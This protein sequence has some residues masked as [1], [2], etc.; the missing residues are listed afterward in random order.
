[1][2]AACMDGP[3]AKKSDRIDFRCSPELRRRLE[4]QCA[5]FNVPITAYITQA[6][7]QR[8]EADEASD[9][10]PEA[11]APEAD[12]AAPKPKPRRKSD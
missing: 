11:P 2:M 10:Q 3:V 9:P 5:R 6:V 1:M 8:L 4:R 12:D 7:V